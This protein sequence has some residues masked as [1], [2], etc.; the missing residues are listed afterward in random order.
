[1]KRPHI[2]VASHERSGTHF[3]INAVTRAYAYPAGSLLNFDNQPLNIN[4]F[5]ARRIADTIGEIATRAQSPTILKSHHPVAF[6]DGVLDEVLAHM[7]L[8]Y[9]HRDP[10][11]TMVSFWRFIHTW[12]WREGP[13]LAD[14]V[15]FAAAEPEGRMMR[16]QVRQYRNLLARWAAHVEGWLAA[17]AKR[18]RL[19]VVRYDA[20]AGAYEETVRG[21]APVLGPLS[22]TLVRPNRFANVVEAAP[23]E[24]LPPPDRE[25]LRA[26]ALAEV[27]DTMRRLGYA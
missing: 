12:P 24:T 8:F 14:A 22:G 5:E 15:A 20:L 23:P 27:G 4:F 17:A 16:Y 1:V 9:I 10:V 19:V 21:F 11:D 7:P 26:L 6:F 18:P 2:I 25:A 3:L 13:R